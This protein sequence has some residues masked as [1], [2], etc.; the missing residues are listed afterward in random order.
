MDS[1]T[2]RQTAAR[3]AVELH[4]ALRTHG[5]SVQVVPEPPTYGQAY[6]TF[7]SALREDEARLITDALKAYPA[8]RNRP[9]SCE[10]CRTIKRDWATAQRA[11]DREG[12]AALAWSMGQ[13]QRRLHS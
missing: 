9:Q 1:E 13:H 5:Y 7:L 6:V 10:E 8:R 4:D 3:V 11:G 2:I 12:A